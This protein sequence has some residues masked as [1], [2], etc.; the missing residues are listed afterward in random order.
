[1]D[2]SALIQWI[3][4]RAEHRAHPIDPSTPFTVRDEGGWAYCPCGAAEGHA[5]YRTGG[6]TR[7]A[8]DRFAWP[9]EETA[10][11]EERSS[12]RPRP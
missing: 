1:M 2:Q 5:W 6:V 7:A 9:S 4:V 10:A 3:C 8:L 11:A 12:E